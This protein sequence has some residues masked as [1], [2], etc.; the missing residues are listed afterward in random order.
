MRLGVLDIGSN[1]A[2]LQ[3][4]DGYPGAP[5]LPAVAVKE[6]TRLAESI[7]EDGTL[8]ADGVARAVHA[9]ESALE[10]ARR[11]RVEQLFVYATSAIRDAA[12]RG[13]ILDRIERET[14]VRPQYLTGEDEARL[15]YSAAHRWYGWSAGRILLLDIG[16][17]SLEIALGRDAEPELTL[18]LPLGAGRLTRKFLPDDPPSR[19]HVKRLRRHV[20]DTLREV[21]DR[22][23]WEGHPAKTVVSSKTFKQLARLCG[24][25][26]QRSGPFV[27][28]TLDAA[29]VRGLLPKLAALPAKKRAKLR[30]VSAP[31]AGQILAGAVVA[32]EA[33]RAFD[34]TTAEV[35]PWALREGI[36]L[37]YL[38]GIPS[39]VH[40]LQL[41]PIRGATD[42]ADSA[43]AAGTAVL[44][45]PDRARS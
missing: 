21:A 9:V 40:E 3:V 22:L 10:A 27:R 44:S 30:G 16:G 32:D 19:K 43:D 28:R 42:V 26:P 25:A 5:P 36:M 11:N 31:R 35:S 6:P 15:T 38:A 29:D 41:Q 8:A 34:I 23:R 2:Q 12:N 4:V 7:E 13:D 1:S 20:H 24:A 14:G 37:R 45:L 18:S 33:F 39:T 17:G